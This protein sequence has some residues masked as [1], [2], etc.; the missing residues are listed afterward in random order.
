MEMFNPIQT[1]LPTF[2]KRIANEYEAMHFYRNAS[3]WCNDAGYVKAAAFF[4]NEAVSE[5]EHSVKVQEFLDDW[6]CRYTLPAINT[7]FTCNS[8]PEIIREAYS[9]YEVPLYKAYAADAEKAMGVDMSAF[10]FL[11][12]MVAI[13]TESVAEYR[14]FID[15][16][17][18]INESNKLDVFLY[19]QNT[20]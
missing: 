3:N 20:F 14:T 16:L 11:Q 1:L 2:I 5:A 7:V 17:N 8:L 10:A 18:L 19:E 9:K 6:G 12:G 15:R 13:Q 4:A